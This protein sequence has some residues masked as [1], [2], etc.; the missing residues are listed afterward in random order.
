MPVHHY[1]FL[2]FSTF[3]FF[4]I[5][6]LAIFHERAGFNCQ[7]ESVFVLMAYCSGEIL[8]FVDLIVQ[9]KTLRSEVA[10][11]IILASSRYVTLYFYV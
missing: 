4:R 3:F 11:V 6:H 1:F 2:D 9:S 5:H 10:T 8:P 7:R